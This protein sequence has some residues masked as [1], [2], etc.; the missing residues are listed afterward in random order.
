[1]TD[2]PTITDPNDVAPAV[3]SLETIVSLS[4]RR[5]FVFPELRDLRRDQRRLG[6]RAA[7]RRAEEQRQARLVAG[8]GPGARRHRRASTPGS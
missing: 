1:M 2:T 6:L 3:A 5:G 7:R 8:D 4:K